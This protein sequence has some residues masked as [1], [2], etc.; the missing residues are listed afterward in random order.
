[1]WNDLGVWSLQGLL[2]W[3]LVTGISRTKQGVGSRGQKDHDGGRGRMV[4]G[5]RSGFNFLSTISWQ[6]CLLSCLF[7]LLVAPSPIYPASQ[8][9]S[10]PPF[11]PASHPVFAGTV[12]GPE[13]VPGVGIERGVLASI[14]DIVLGLRGPERAGGWSQERQQSQCNVFWVCREAGKPPRTLFG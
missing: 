7:F 11:H 8:R 3:C 12:P 5:F 13:P 14:T 2:G 4:Q 6:I 10:H 9:T 1:M